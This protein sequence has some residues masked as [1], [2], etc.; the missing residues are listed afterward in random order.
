MQSMKADELPVNPRERSN[1]F[2]E[3]FFWWVGIST[4]QFQQQNE[5][6]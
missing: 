3:L 4:A 1:P 5:W 6:V 2:S